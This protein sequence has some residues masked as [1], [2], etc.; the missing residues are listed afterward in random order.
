MAWDS[1][2]CGGFV[3]QVLWEIC[4]LG[5]A[6]GSATMGSMSP[7]VQG[8]QYL[9]LPRLTRAVRII[10]IVT[11]AVFLC[12]LLA[13]NV[14]GWP[15][16]ERL[17]SLH[18]AGILHG[19][20]WQLV[21]YMFLHS[22]VNLLHIFMNMIGL[23]FMGPDVE[24]AIGTKRFLL[25]YFGCGIMGGIGWLLLSQQ[26]GGYCI[27]ASG[28]VFGVLG[29]FAGLF[30]HRPVTLLL[31][32]V[33]PVTVA[34]RTLA[35]IFGLISLL[36]VVLLSE[37]GG[38][39][40]SAHLAGGLAGY[41]YAV[42]LARRYA[43]GLSDHPVDEVFQGPGWISRLMARVASARR[44]RLH[45]PAAE[46]DRILEKVAEKGLHSLT[47]RERDTLDRASRMR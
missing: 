33:L 11:G 10:L 7:W 29:A 13:W 9:A 5:E 22:R 17:F 3:Q 27:G 8:E 6:G 24:R 4:G 1:D 32:F 45:P 36:M 30:P 18:K 14:F 23:Y 42:R 28:A 40:H 25:L 19:W 46:V 38:V 39:A 44:M 26:S 2:Q 37:G 31:M 34:A 43:F 16:I 47:G 41:L 21:T 35:I 15:G 20:T 12:Q